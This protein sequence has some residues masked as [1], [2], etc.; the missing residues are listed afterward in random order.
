[1]AA[2]A[3][4]P[5]ITVHEHLLAVNLITRTSVAGQQVTPDRAI[6]VYALEESTGAVQT[7]LG[8]SIVLATG[9]LGKVYLYTSNPDV[10]TG[11]GHAMALRAG[12]MM[13]NMEFVQ[14]HPTC[15]FHPHAKSFLIS[16]ALRGEGGTL[17]R[18]DGTAFMGSYHKLRD[19]APRDIVARAI[20][21]ELKESGDDCVYLDMTHL[22]RPFVEKRFPNIHARC[23]ALGIDMVETPLPVVP[24]AHYACGGVVT[25]EHGATSIPGLYAVGEV[26]CTG[27]HGANRLASNS[28]LEAVVYAHRAAEHARHFIATH[29]TPEPPARAWNI[30]HARNSEELVMVS[31]NWDEI[32][33]LMWNYVGI[34]RSTKRLLRARARI[35]L[36]MQEIHQYYWDFRITR[37]LI[38]LRNITLV[39]KCIIESALNRRESRGLHYTLDHPEQDESLCEP[40]VI[41]RTDL[42]M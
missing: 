21:Q 23:L 35:D 28:L 42:G 9:G 38:E 13:G 5:N 33:R 1:V 37:D 2:T 36:I 24:A 19:L 3:E 10:A 4:H 41:N 7:F 30:G 11:D 6:G 34:V 31:H 22:D 14:F 29:S 15:L 27:L 12:A 26:T 20:D 40:T 8:R 32:R 17:K 18:A 25:D 39:A 16:E